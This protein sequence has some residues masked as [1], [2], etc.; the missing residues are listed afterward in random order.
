MAQR[1]V[2]PS[3][4]FTK[5]DLDQL[6]A[7]ISQEP[8]RTGY[9]ALV[10]DSRSKLTYAMQGPFT[11]VGRAPNLHNDQWKSDMQAI[12]NLTFMWIFTG[13]SAY[14][15]KATNMLDTWAVTNTVWSGGEAML[16]IG[17]YV[18]YFVT[19]ADILRGL[20]PGW[21]DSNT[22]HVKKYFANVIWPQSWVPSPPRDNNKGALQ[23]GIGLSVAAFLDDKVK[24]DQTVELYRLDA[25]AALRCSLPN[26]EV[27][28][29]GRD[30]HWF[31]QAFALIYGAEIAWK[32]GVDLYSEYGNRLHA[33][34]ELYNKYSFVGDTMTFIPFGGS[35]NYWLNWGIGTGVRHQHPFN[36]LIKGAYAQRKGIATPWTEQMRTAVGEGVMVVFIFKIFRYFHGSTLIAHCFSNYRTG[37]AVKQYGYR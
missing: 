10:N 11:E 14:A 18:P 7:N 1:F 33:I 24:W 5:Y 6:K 21:S 17:D 35:A 13:D 3:I 20:F 28:D 27:G 29:A 4:P 9:N 19:A 15:R 12:H 37:I 26:G 8:W 31:V 16:D 25:T 2:H 32:Q 30:D 34:G 23:M 36:N 22:V